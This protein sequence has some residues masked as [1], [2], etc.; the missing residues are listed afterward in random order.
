MPVWIPE[1]KLNIIFLDVD[2]VLNGYNRWNTLGWN[3]VCWFDSERLR[4]WYRKLTDPSGVHESKV[5]RLAKIVRKTN[6][7][8]VMSSTWRFGYWKV[9]YEKQWRNVQK[10]T[11]LL[12]KYSI[13]VIDITPRSSNGRREDEILSWLSNHEYKVNK[14]IVIDDDR[15]DLECFAN[16]ELIYTTSVSGR[17]LRRKHVKKAIKILKGA[18]Q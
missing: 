1:E 11:D 2:G 3:V 8:V 18:D 12:N 15:F 17:G 10:L 16:K 9:P 7:R 5:K 14:F 4:N 13:E 6:A